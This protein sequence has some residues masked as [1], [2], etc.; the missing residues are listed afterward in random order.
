[1]SDLEDAGL[2]GARGD[3]AGLVEPT[4][5]ASCWP[6]A[7]P[8][9]QAAEG[10]TVTITVG[11]AALRRAGS[12]CATLISDANLF[13]GDHPAPPPRARRAPRSPSWRRS[14]GWPSP[15]SRAASASR[16][17][18]TGEEL[19]ASTQGALATIERLGPITLGELAAVEQVQPPSMTRI[20]ARLEEWGYATRVV[21][22]AD[23]RVGA[24]RASPT[25]V[26]SCSRAAALARTRSSPGASPSSPTPSARCSPRALPLLERLQDDAR[27]SLRGDVQVAARP[28]LPAVLLR[29]ADLAVRHLDADDRPRLAGAAP[30]AQQRLRDRARHR[31]AV[32]PHAA[33]RRVGRRASPTASTSAP[34]C[35]SRRWRWRAVAVLLA[36]LDLTNVVQLWM[37]YV[38]VFVFGLALAVDNPTRQSFVPELVPPDDL[39]NAIGLSSAIFQVA[40]ILGP[41]LGGVLI[42]AVGTGVCFVLNAVSFVFIIAALL[43]MR[44]ERAAPRSAARAREGPDPRRPALRLAHARAAVDAAAHAHRRDVRDQLAGRPAAAGQDHV[45]RQRRG[46]QLDDDRDGRRARSFGALFVA[47]RGAR[48]R[49]ASSSPPAWRSASPSASRRS[50]RRWRCSSRCSLVVGAG[51]ISFL[52]TCNSLAP[53]PLGS[54]DARPGDGGVHDHPARQHAHRRSAG[55]VDQRASSGPAGASP[56]AASPP[57]SACWLFGT[58]FVRARRRDERAE[59]DRGARRA[60]ARRSTAESIPAVRSGE[61]GAGQ[62]RRARRRAARPPR[63]P[64]RDRRRARRRC[65]RSADRCRRRPTT[66]PRARCRWGR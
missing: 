47:N 33:V 10:S 18:V 31:A 11:A 16:P 5:T 23:R 6:R 57:S 52:A 25:P 54:G 63:A 41:A 64:G 53:A 43:M 51:Q 8:A 22:P 19:T 45:R 24:R 38:I 42:V 48:A 9:G 27:M 49:V 15:G 1:M 21:D 35:S 20:V 36:V 4:R 59:R 7:R 2:R 66:T 3:H 28:Q 12:I 34:S 55:R 40:R 60:R 46:L 56:S 50:R 32:H 61:P 37:I 30:L 29:P 65:S 39:P 14:C 62:R 13:A 58:A 44:T 26:A 17:R